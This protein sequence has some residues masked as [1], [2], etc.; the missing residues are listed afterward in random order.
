MIKQEDEKDF[1]R[2]P[3]TLK[4]QQDHQIG[5][6]EAGCVCQSCWMFRFDICDKPYV[7]HSADWRKNFDEY[8]DIEEVAIPADA[9]S[10]FVAIRW[11]NECFPGKSKNLYVHHFHN[12]YLCLPR[13]Y[14]FQWNE[15]CLERHT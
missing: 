2:F 4:I 14:L 5:I 15:K 13:A 6:R 9:V 8:G 10:D 3:G 11:D 7:K 1:E 12:T